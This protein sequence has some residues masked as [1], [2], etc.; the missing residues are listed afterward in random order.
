MRTALSEEIWWAEDPAKPKGL[1]MALLIS[2]LSY[3]TIAF[4]AGNKTRIRSQ[5]LSVSKLLGSLPLSTITLAL[6]V[7]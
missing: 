4:I 6:G 1:S 3:I 2:V 5:I 7:A